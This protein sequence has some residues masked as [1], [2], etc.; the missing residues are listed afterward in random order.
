MG[1]KPKAPAAVASATVAL[2]RTLLAHCLG[3]SK[4]KAIVVDKLGSCWVIV[5]VV[6]AC[7]QVARPSS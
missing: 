4:D 7:Q 1:A 2:L 5:L 3:L 6:V